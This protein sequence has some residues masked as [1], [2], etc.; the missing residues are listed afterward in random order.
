MAGEGEGDERAEKGD[1]YMRAEWK[2]RVW[3]AMVWGGGSG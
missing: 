1:G 2:C 3:M